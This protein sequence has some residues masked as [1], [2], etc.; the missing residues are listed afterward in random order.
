MFV[1][2]HYPKLAAVCKCA[3]TNDLTVYQRLEDKWETFNLMKEFGIPTP[4]TELFDA[5]LEKQ[6]YPFFL[7]VASGTNA[8]RGVW[9]CKND[10]DLQEALK[11]KETQKKGALLL[12]QAPTYGDI[13]CAE[14]IYNHGK[15]LGFFFAKSVQVR[16]TRRSCIEIRSVCRN[17]HLFLS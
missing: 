13:I 15:P 14:I 2:E 9:H 6:D 8:G 7:K 4:D 1:A 11:D 16:G 10:E 5:K 17:S 3:I 12:R